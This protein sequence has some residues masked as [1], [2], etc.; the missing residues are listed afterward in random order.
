MRLIVY[1]V[2]FCEDTVEPEVGHGSCSETAERAGFSAS[3][4]YDCSRVRTQLNNLPTTHEVAP[5]P[6]LKRTST[7]S[8]ESH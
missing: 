5:S 6:S 8:I 7:E 1:P 3:P 2:S 4:L